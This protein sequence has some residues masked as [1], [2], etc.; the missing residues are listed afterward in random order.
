MDHEPERDCRGGDVDLIRG[1]TQH[2]RIRSGHPR[3]GHLTTGSRC[4]LPG[5]AP[6][7]PA[8]GRRVTHRTRRIHAA[9][10]AS[11]TVRA[12]LAW[13]IQRPRHITDTNPRT[14]DSR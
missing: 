1:T 3:H 8:R 13:G 9:T 11:T 6:T 5:R 14:R 4:P 10:E 2:S 7:C 12:G